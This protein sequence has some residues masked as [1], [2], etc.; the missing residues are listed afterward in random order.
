MNIFWFVF[1]GVVL[2]GFFYFVA[3]LEGT[4]DG[5]ISWGVVILLVLVQ[6]VIILGACGEGMKSV[7]GL[8]IYTK[9]V[10]ETKSPQEINE[11][12]KELKDLKYTLPEYEFI[13]N[14]YILKED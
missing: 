5:K 13:D 12:L 14:K 6:I 3:Y 11:Y 4:T 10:F 9:H 1:V 2:F 8:K 7:P